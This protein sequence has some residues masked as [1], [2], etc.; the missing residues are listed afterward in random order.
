[1]P[2]T[3]VADKVIESNTNVLQFK[4]PAA[5]NIGNAATQGEELNMANNEIIM[6]LSVN[7]EWLWSCVPRLNLPMMTKVMP[8]TIKIPPAS[9]SAM[10]SAYFVM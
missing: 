8:S 4:V 6:V 7:F 9:G 5:R 10:V 2:E 3:V 1:M